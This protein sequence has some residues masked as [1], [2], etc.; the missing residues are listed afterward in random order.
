MGLRISAAALLAIG[1]CLPATAQEAASP[2]PEMDL[3]C[4]HAFATV[5]AEI[6]EDDA[7]F[8]SQLEA[9]SEF[10]LARGLVGLTEAG[11]RAGA[12]ARSSELEARA[13]TQIEGQASAADFTFEQCFGLLEAEAAANVGGAVEAPDAPAADAPAA[14]TPAAP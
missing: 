13:D 4:G 9:G 8:S 12:E 11:D 5:S 3:W 10:L 1:L 6:G 2:G 7:D 14:T